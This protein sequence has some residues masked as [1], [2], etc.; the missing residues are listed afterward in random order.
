M[1]SGEFTAYP[2]STLVAKDASNLLAVYLDAVFAPRL[3]ARDLA[4]EGHRLAPRDGGWARTGVVYHEMQGAFDATSPV[5]ER[6]A[7]AA[8]VPDTCWAHD[9]GGDPAEITA[10]DR[11]ALVDFHR[12][13][14]CPANAI[15]CTFGQIDPGE[16][17]AAMQPYLAD[18]GVGL[19]IPAAQPPWTGPRRVEVAVPWGEDSD[20]ADASLAGLHWLWGDLAEVD[21]ALAEELVDRLLTGHAGSPPRLGR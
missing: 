4:Q 5:I 10:I 17:Q 2:F 15:L 16:I 14:Y 19:G 8:L 3:D 20:L 11:A 21:E 7:T 6:A 12:R 18:P 9:S 13:C 1:T